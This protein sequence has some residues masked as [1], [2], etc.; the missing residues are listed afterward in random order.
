MEEEFG[1]VCT[2]LRYIQENILE[3][4]GSIRNNQESLSTVDFKSDHGIF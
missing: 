1:L 4:E 3:G 2:E